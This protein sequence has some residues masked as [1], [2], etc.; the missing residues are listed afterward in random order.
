MK[1]NVFAA[2]IAALAAMSLVRTTSVGNMVD[3]LVKSVGRTPRTTPILNSLNRIAQL[4][5]SRNAFSHT[6]QRMFTDVDNG[7]NPINYGGG[8]LGAYYN[9]MFPDNDDYPWAC[10]CN[11]HDLQQ[12][13]EKLLPYA[14]C[15]NQEDLSFNNFQANCN[16]NTGVEFL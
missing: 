16:P 4:P 9:F 12:Y 8:N 13:K 6:L 14:K 10:V 11:E 7:T 15:R 2:F 3:S 5:M 1:L